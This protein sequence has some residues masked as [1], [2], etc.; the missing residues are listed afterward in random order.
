MLTYT[1]AMNIAYQTWYGSDVGPHASFA[2]AVQEMVVSRRPRRLCEIGAGANPIMSSAAAAQ[3]GVLEY[4]VTDVSEQ[5][6]TKASDGYIKVVADVTRGPMRELGAFELI[7]SQ[8]VA[9][10]VR[11]PAAFHQTTYDMLVPGGR[12]MHFFPT[13]YEPAC[14]V[15][16]LLPEFAADAIL[17][18]IQG[19]R[20]RGGMNEKFPAFYRWCRGPT[21]RQLAR[22][23]AIGFEIEEYVGVF[24]HDYYRTVPLIDRLETALAD[25][26]VRHPLPSLTSYSSVTLRRS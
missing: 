23:T 4:V 25:A 15:N 21:R 12:A 14:V 26:L 19:G 17:Q 24:G 11:D 13:L 2:R 6:L 16:R 8:T 5:E 22:F 20:T 3:A 10:H 9:E 1:P 18:R 7:V